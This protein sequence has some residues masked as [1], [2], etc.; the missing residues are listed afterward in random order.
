MNSAYWGTYGGGACPRCY[1]SLTARGIDFTPADAASILNS[2]IHGTIEYLTRPQFK[3]AIK[4]MTPKKFITGISIIGN[5]IKSLFGKRGRGF[6]GKSKR[7]KS[8]DLFGGSNI[9]VRLLKRV[10][11]LTLLR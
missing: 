11:P 2:P 3:E 1:R 6:I 9:P 8:K 5:K 10:M 7:R 4:K